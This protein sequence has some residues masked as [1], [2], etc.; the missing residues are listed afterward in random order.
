MVIDLRVE[1]NFHDILLIVPIICACPTK[2]GIENL[3]RA[4]AVEKKPCPFA[5]GSISPRTV[6]FV[7]EEA[8]D[9]F[10]RLISV[11]VAVFVFL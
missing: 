1:I 10:R 3:H 4:A 8:F 7:E 6:E 9:R 5:V 11:E 2:S